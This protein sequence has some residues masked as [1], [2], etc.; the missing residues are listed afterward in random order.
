MDVKDIAELD[1]VM[2]KHVSENLP[3]DIFE[4]DTK[5]SISP[6]KLSPPLKSKQKSSPLSITIKD[7]FEKFSLDNFMECEEEVDLSFTVVKDEAID[8]AN[9]AAEDAVIDMKVDID[10]DC[11]DVETVSEQIPGEYSC[12]THNSYNMI[13]PAL[14]RKLQFILKNICTFAF[15]QLGAFLLL[16]GNINCS[17]YSLNQLH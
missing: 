9:A 11:I 5:L 8:V 2:P 7:E 15:G 6:G 4:D 14:L 17:A 13:T 16:C 12:L 3:D 10:D 1:M